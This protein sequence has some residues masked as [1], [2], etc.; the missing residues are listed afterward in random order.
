[1]AVG[2]MPAG[3]TV[4]LP[5]CAEA[6]NPAKYRPITMS[7]IV[8]RCFHRILAQWMEIHLPFSTRQKAFRPGDGVADSVWFI[9]AVIKHHQD[10]LRPL[11]VAFVDVKKAFNSVSHQ[12]ILVAA[13]R[14]AV[15]PPFL[16]YIRELY[17]NAVTT[18]R[19]GPDISAPIRLGRGVRQGNPF[20]VHLSNAVIDMCLAGLDPTLGC[21]VGDLRVNHGAFA[22]D[23]ALFAATPRGLQALAS[24]LESQ[25]AM[26]G[27]SISSGPRGRSASMHLDIDGKA[28]KW[29]I[30]PLSYLRVA[31]AIVPA[32][33]VCQVYR[34]LGVDVSPCRTRANVASMLRDG[35]ASISSAPPQAAAEALHRYI[36]STA[37]VSPSVG[38]LPVVGQVPTMAGPDGV[39]CSKVLV[40]TAEGHPG[41][42]LPR[43]CGRG[44]TWCPSP[45]ARCAA[46]EG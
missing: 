44:R 41:P 25:L 33:S 11:S 13:A 3:K 27:L 9:Q 17:S 6:E 22:D 29:V 1:M 39:F 23:I 20:S 31:G 37:Q 21:K 16:R 46:H 43:P 35:L 34:Y 32:V 42:L 4:L 40:E 8:V 14:L 7:D 18:L 28:K 12:S 30:N 15:P 2:W 19:I 5:K 10:S 45:Q 38:S 26:R 36:P 24:E